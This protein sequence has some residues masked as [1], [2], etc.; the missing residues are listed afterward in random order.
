VSKSY[1]V[2]MEI[3][4]PLAMFTRPDTGASPTSYP[5]PT[6]SACKGI[7][8]AIAFQSSGDAWIN[9]TRVEVCRHRDVPGGE[10][11]LNRYTTNY[12]GPL[13]KTS[14]IRSGSSFQ[15][16]ATVLTDVCYRIYG[17]VVGKP[18]SRGV[19]PRHQLQALF[20]RRCA[21]GQSWRSPALGWKE[22]TASYWGP[23]REEYVV[24]EALELVIPSMLHSMWGNGPG[25]G[26]SPEFRQNVKI[27]KGV[28]T[29]A[30]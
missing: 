13:R 2:Q 9:P 28:L 16:F 29:F 22:F 26:Y 20:Q 4:G 1:L 5:A 27:E 11:R 18:Q 12:G 19:N 17:E 15:L 10:V 14:V 30:E 23:F 8:E 6:W 7:F 3:A 24:D 21:Q 25:G